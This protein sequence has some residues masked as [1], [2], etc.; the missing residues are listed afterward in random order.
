GLEAISRGASH[1]TFVENNSR[2][3]NT[4]EKN[5]ESLNVEAPKYTVL[6]SSAYMVFDRLDRDGERFDLIF[7]DP[8]YHKDMARK[9]LLYIDNYDILTAIG[10][11]VVEHFK[12]DSLEAEL[13][14]MVPDKERKY[15]DTLITIFKKFG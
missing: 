4:I 10:M 2:C 15:G 6:R 1:V 11:V 9:C 8:P 13:N 12:A 5:L 7:V 14:T 3:L